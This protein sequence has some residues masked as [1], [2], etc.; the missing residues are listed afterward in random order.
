MKEVVKFGV[1]GMV[2][3]VLCLICD[4]PNGYPKKYDIPKF[5]PRFPKP[6]LGDFKIPNLPIFR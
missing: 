3:V 4:K 6:D 1:M 2:K 5:N